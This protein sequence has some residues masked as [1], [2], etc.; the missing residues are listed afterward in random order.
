MVGSMS[1]NAAYHVDSRAEG[2]PL[3]KVNLSTSK[4]LL[5]PEWRVPK[6]HAGCGAPSSSPL[7]GSGGGW[8]QCF[9]WLRQRQ[10]L[11]IM[12]PGPLVSRGTEWPVLVSLLWPSS[13]LR[14]SLT[15][16]ISMGHV[17]SA[18]EKDRWHA[19]PTRRVRN[20]LASGQSEALLG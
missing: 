6:G 16:K 2:G 18:K 9:L 5:D 1:P 14:A 20:L 10:P 12:A 11:A 17:A 8:E 15:E 3:R 19:G 4:Q 7:A 13:L